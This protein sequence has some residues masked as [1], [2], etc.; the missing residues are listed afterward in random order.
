MERHS[1]RIGLG[2]SYLNF[3]FPATSDKQS[4]KL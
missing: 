2:Y 3:Q 4:I 1:G